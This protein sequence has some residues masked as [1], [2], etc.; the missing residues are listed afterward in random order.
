MPQITLTEE[1][2]E[3]LHD[4]MNDD[5]LREL[6]EVEYDAGS[7]LEEISRVVDAAWMDIDMPGDIIGHPDGTETVV[8]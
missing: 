2:V 5:A 4:L 1:Q 8:E 6:A 3:L 7:E